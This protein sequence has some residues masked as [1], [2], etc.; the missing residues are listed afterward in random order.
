MDRYDFKLGEKIG[1]KSRHGS[2]YQSYS[3]KDMVIK[4]VLIKSKKQYKNFLNE[5]HFQKKT[6]NMKI[7]PKIYCV[8]VEKNYGYIL[9]EKCKGETMK[10]VLIAYLDSSIKDDEK[11]EIIL[12]LCESVIEKLVALVL[13]KI[14]HG[15]CHVDN[16]II[17]IK[18]NEIQ[19][20]DYGLAYTTQELKEGKLDNIGIFI[21][22][23]LSRVSKTSSIIKNVY[24]T[25]YDKYFL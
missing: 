22:S 2:I 5:V 8:L 14:S 19:L 20:I 12:N 11:T 4:K 15:D 1:E 25:I 16:I 23:L 13:L 24:N 10:K 3:R 17:D 9:M 7:T 6:E 18:S 21:D